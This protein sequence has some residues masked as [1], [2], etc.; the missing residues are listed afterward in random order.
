MKFSKNIYN[1][2]RTKQGNTKRRLECQSGRNSL[3][4]T[5]QLVNIYFF[6]KINNRPRKFTTYLSHISC[7]YYSNTIKE[8]I[9]SS[10]NACMSRNPYNYNQLFFLIWSIPLCY[11]HTGINPSKNTTIL[12]QNKSIFNEYT[13]ILR[14]ACCVFRRIDSCRI[15]IRFHAYRISDI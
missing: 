4:N 9:K 11:K 12:S 10:N 2:I 13:L 6:L 5:D 3:Q 1:Y 15:I 14:K 8:F 7:S